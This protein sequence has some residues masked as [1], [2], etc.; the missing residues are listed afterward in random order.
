MAEPTKPRTA[1]I[2]VGPRDRGGRPAIDRVAEDRTA[3]VYVTIHYPDGTTATAGPT[4]GG[5]TGGPVLAR[6]RRVPRPRR[7]PRAAAGAAR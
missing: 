6:P 1:T 4:G 5:P 7:R 3:D 2:H